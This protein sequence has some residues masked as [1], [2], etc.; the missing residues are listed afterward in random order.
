M[1]LGIKE[2]RETIDRAAVKV[3]ES[4]QTITLGIT[5]ALAIAVGAALLAGIALALAIRVKTS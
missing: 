4:A 3:G 1:R 5:T 2:A